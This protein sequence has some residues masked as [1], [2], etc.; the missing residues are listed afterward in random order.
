MPCPSNVSWRTS[1]SSYGGSLLPTPDHRDNPLAVKDRHVHVPLDVD[2]ARGIT[3]LQ[4][5]GSR[6]IVGKH[7]LP[8]PHGFA[9]QAG[10]H[11]GIVNRL[12]DNRALVH[13]RLGPGVHRQDAFVFVEKGEVADP[14]LRQTHPCFQD[15]IRDVLQRRV[16]HLVQLQQGFQPRLLQPQC[17]LGTL[18]LVLGLHVVQRKGDVTCD[19]GHQIQL[20]RVRR[21]GRRNRGD[22]HA[23]HVVVPDQSHRQWSAAAFLGSQGARA[24][25]RLPVFHRDHGVRRQRPLEAGDGLPTP[26]SLLQRGKFRLPHPGF[27]GRDDLAGLVQQHDPSVAVSARLDQTVANALQQPIPIPFSRD[28]LVHV[29]DRTQHGVQVLG[30]LVGFS[31]LRHVDDEALDRDH[32]PLLGVHPGALFPNPFFRAVGGADPVHQPMAAALGDRLQDAPV[33]AVHILRMDQLLVAPA[34]FANQV[35]RRVAGQVK[36]A[37]AD[38]FHRPRLVA[39]AP[40]S[41]ARQVVH[42]RTELPLAFDQR[43][44]S[45]FEAAKDRSDPSDAGE[46]QQRDGEAEALVRQIGCFH[47]V[48]IRQAIQ[49]NAAADQHRQDR[50][51]QRDPSPAETGHPNQP[52]RQKGGGQLK[53]DRQGDDDDHGHDSRL[54]VVDV[55]KCQSSCC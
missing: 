49:R 2:V 27:S 38:E 43:L 47:R 6:V 5:I 31:F 32:F 23:V 51:R 8:L 25:Q 17:V 35:A 16:G 36:A 12:V 44:L 11:H 40:I 13:R 21:K 28:D 46:H 7:G 22:H 3:L 24:A 41:H 55:L 54:A 33:H 15:E 39:A 14:A 37:L 34:A 48:A 52:D 30:T 26:H 19:L 42:Q 53:Q 20:F 4:R 1:E 45:Q 10:R 18:T 9:P 50:Q 29:A